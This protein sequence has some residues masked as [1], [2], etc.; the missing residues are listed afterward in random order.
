MKTHFKYTMIALV[1]LLVVSL[2]V[3]GGLVIPSAAAGTSYYVD[4]SAPTNGDGSQSSPWNN[5]DTVSALTFSP[6]DSLLFKR[7]TTCTGFFYFDSAGTSTDRITIGAYGTGALPII[8]G[9]YTQATVEL[10]NPD[11]VTMQDLEIVN[12]RTWGILAT[13]DVEGVSYGLILQDLVVNHVTGGVYQEQNRKWTGLVVLAPGVVDLP[14]L[15]S[16]GGLKWNWERDTHFED[17][18]VD[19]V[20]AYDTTLWGGIFVWGMQ[21]EGD[22]SWKRH[23][24]DRTRRSKNIDIRNSLVHDTFGDGFA[25]YLSD[26]VLMESN[27]VYRSGMEPPNPE[28]PAGGTTGT[29]VALWYWSAD[30]VTAQF[31]EAYDNHSPG[32]DGGA[33]DLDYWSSNG[34]YQYNYA[35][36]NSAYCVGIFGAEGDPTINSIF[37]YNIC[38][39]NGTQATLIDGSPKEGRGEIYPCTWN[40]GSLDGVQVYNNTLYVT[41]SCAVDWCSGGDAR[42]TS[43]PMTF[44]NNLIVSTLEDPYGPGITMFPWDRDH[45]LWTYTGGTIAPDPSPEPN[46]IYNQDPLVNGM[47]YHGIGMPTTEWTLQSGS[48]AINA[49][50]DPC[51]G[52]PDCTSGGRDFY[53]NAVPAGAFDIGAHEYGSA[54]PPPTDT[55]TPPTETPEPPSMHVGDIAMS[56]QSLPGSRYRALATVTILDM[57]DQPVDTATVHGEFTGATSDSVSGDTI[58]DGTVTLESSAKKNGGTWMFC[59][60]GVVKTGWVYDDTANV[61]T[62]D[63]ITAP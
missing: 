54:P 33:Y 18:L 13:T 11:Y 3:C 5:L 25:V 37:R 19:N 53:G 16:D 14:Q 41:Q 36:D 52:V 27:V 29:P 15:D 38:A 17:V 56:F 57:A 63:S 39:G 62:C 4:C 28:D 12:G 49:G 58:G 44:R 34:T 9:N 8:D 1:A 61:E 43:A 32:V 22:T 45:N 31:N 40:R 21:L 2:V 46:G 55:P 60:T 50:M 30:D 23:A 35:H 59:V 24:K 51:T 7:G 10:M 6:G 20:T 47:G 42:Y 26:N 48:P